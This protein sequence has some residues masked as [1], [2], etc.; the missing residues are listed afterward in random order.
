MIHALVLLL[1]GSWLARDAPA[2]LEAAP[3]EARADTL[4]IRDLSRPRYRLPGQAGEP[5][6]RLGL[7]PVSMSLPDTVFRSWLPD[8]A[9]RL[10]WLRPRVPVPPVRDPAA[11]EETF[12][13]LA[14]A[15]FLEAR[16]RAGAAPPPPV[17]FLPPRPGAADPDSLAGL[18]DLPGAMGEYTDLGMRVQTRA[19]LGGD[20]TRFRP[21]TDQFQESCQPSLVPRLEPDLNFAV[22]VQG[23]VLDRVTVDVD[24]DRLREFGG[25]NTI[26]LVYDGSEDDILQRFAVGDVTF[27]LPRSRFLTQGVPAGNFGFQLEGQLGPVDFRSVWAEQRGDVSSREFRLTGVGQERRFVQSDTLVLD[28]AD[29]ARG[30]FFFLVNPEVI[31]DYPYVDVLS[32]DAGAVSPTLVPGIEPVQLYRYDNNPAARQQVEGY[33]QADASAQLGTES[34]TESG[35][36]RYLVPGQDYFL[37]PSGLWVALRIPLG[38]DEMLAAT[39]VT[40]AGD[41]VGDYNPEEV[42]NQGLRPQLRLLKAT[43]ANHQPGRPTWELEMRQVYRV[44]TSPDVEEASVEVTISLGELSAGR[45]F[46]RAPSGRDITFLQLFGVDRESPLDQ[47]DPAYV[48]TPGAE[49]FQDPPAVPGTFLVFPSLRPFLEPGP[50]PSLGLSAGDA[51]ALLGQDANDRIY[52]AE[53]PFDRRNGGLFRLTIPFRVRSEGVISTFSLGALGVLEGSERILLGDRLLIRGVDYEIDYDAGLVRLLDPDGLFATAP[54]AAVRATWEQQQVFRTAPT[55]VF[56][57]NVHTGSRERGELDLLALYQSEK[58][59]VNRPILGLEP[60]AVFLTGLS[61]GVERP[62]GWLDQALGAVPGL[63]V[64]EASSFSLEGELAVSLP[65]PNTRGEVFVDD[66]DASDARPLSLLSGDWVR[67]SPAESRTGAEVIL[68]ATLGPAEQAELAWQHSWIVEDATGD[69]VGIHEGYLPREEIDRQIRVA[70]SQVREAG[71]RLSFDTDPTGEPFWNALTTVLSPTGTDLTRSEFLEFYVAGGDAATLVVDL[72]VSSEDVLFVDAQ[73][74]TSGTNENGVPWGFGRLDQEAD[75]ARGQVWGNALDQFGVWGEDCLA[76]PGRIY[77]LGDPRANCTRGNGRNDSEDLDGDGVLDTAERSLRYVV[78]LDGTS[79]FLARTRNETGTDFRLYRI[80]IRGAGIEV[81]GPVTEADLRAVRHVRLTVV[82]DRDAEFTLARMRIVGSRWIRRTAD[83]VLTGI[84]GDT[85]AFTGRT[86]VGPVSRLIE[87]EAYSSPPGVLE[88]LSDP[89]TA[90]GA[91]GIEFNERSLSIRVQDLQ[92]G[93]R[94]EVFTRFPQRPRNFLTYRE[95]RLWVVPRSGDWSPDRPVSF[96]LK[97][98]TD[99]ENFYLYRTPLRAPANPAAVSTA[100]WLPEVVVDFNEFLALRTRAEEELILDPPDPGDPPVT[101]WSA[102]STYAVVLRDRGRAPD[103][104]NVRELALGIWNQDAVPFNGEVWV[105]ELRLGRGDTDPGVAGLVTASL[106][107]GDV[108]TTD[109]TLS[110]RSGT[111]RQLRE[112]AS[113]Q[114]DQRLTLNARARLDRLAPASWGV[115]IPLAVTL[116]RSTLDPRFLNNSDVRAD[117]LPN[118]RETGNRRTQVSLGFRKVTP[119]AN[120]WVGALVDG[121]EANV[122]AYRVRNAS[123]TSRVESRGLDARVGYARRLEPREFDPIPGF[124][125]PVARLLLPGGLEDAVLGARIRWLPER[126]SVGTA[127][128]RRDDDI[129]R[130]Q[131][132]IVTDEDREVLPQEA[133]REALELAG[134]L[135]MQPVP[136]LTADLSFRSYRDL[137]RPTQSVT[138]PGVQELLANERAR[139]A[140]MDLGWETDRTLTT[141]LT[142]R[143]RI[144]SWLQHQVGWTTRYASQ[145]NPSFLGF[146]GPDSTLA[147]ERNVRVERA[148]QGRVA[149]DPAAVARTVWGEGSPVFAPTVLRIFRPLTWDATDGITSRFSRA[150]VDPGLGYQFGFEDV[151]G[152]RIL[153]QDTAVT[154]T[155]GL[156][157]RLGW[158]IGGNRA[159]LDVAWAGSE[160]TALDVRADR[161]ILSTTWPDVRGRIAGVEAL[162]WL[163]PGLT[164][165]SFSGGFLR[166]R[167][168]TRLGDGLQTRKNEEIQLPWD[169]TFSWVGTLVTAYRGSLLDGEG[170]DPTGDTERDRVTH[171]VS[172]SSSFLPPFG[173]SERLSGPVQLSVIAS[174]GAERECRVPRSRPECVP[175]VDQ[176][177][178]ALSLSMDTRLSDFQLGIQASYTDRRS[179]VGRRQGSTQFQLGIF[180]TFLFEAGRIGDGFPGM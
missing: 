53:D 84:I 104:A 7:K 98:G 156:S 69:S 81:N 161:E 55:S 173:L 79:P 74:Q 92:P 52:T 150:P 102:D 60:G 35:W 26:S 36:F 109:L 137:L 159:S 13:R 129:Y 114:T 17:A 85:L 19:E 95:A 113:Y 76:E 67:G 66:F 70:G 105:N 59:L 24:Y 44:S 56:A 145:R 144:W 177:N 39:W 121:L 107:A 23:T 77:R 151:N 54:D 58:T 111:F 28:D 46:K 170:Q 125:E 75:P 14:V 169:I 45:T 32:L 179:F 31:N 160:I 72:G 128:L 110:T 152:F 12:T 82:G 64:G 61:G 10:P 43:D 155:D 122:A 20:W 88:Q 47:V 180:G 162:N 37:H 25:T 148:V 40:A 143:P 167:R 6:A 140:G 142:Y 33:I 93:D 48:Y 21:C 116:D 175:F 112:T 65:T 3:P 139:F 132:I 4:Y 136:S 149:L 171:R 29:Y 90:V 97:V 135:V 68:P 165:V 172:F 115:D 127:Y 38:P 34:V 130:F 174:Y 154:L 166:N 158:G 83:G 101:I 57:F 153:Q 118:L 80:P 49:L 27:R 16:A 1:A 9:A 124:L 100:D 73:G 78:T 108:V 133:P 178:R 94:G 157:Q 41:T 71:L 22:Q 50:V 51:Q 2:P 119:S 146:V 63:R 138:D 11:P 87:G 30:Q 18:D 42:Y 89:T 163:A 123:V 8:P 147:L 117:R 141:R 134:E 131:R 164:S 120:P 176:I 126:F 168:E 99:P 62:V 15:D 86:E 96:F 103:L 106:E 5:V 91:Q